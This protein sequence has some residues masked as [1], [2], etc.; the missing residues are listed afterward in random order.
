VGEDSDGH[1]QAFNLEN[2]T[3]KIASQIINDTIGGDMDLCHLMSQ[4]AGWGQ[5]KSNDK[6]SK[7]AIY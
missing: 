2:S 5:P 6:L 1:F 7:L 4:G 3:K